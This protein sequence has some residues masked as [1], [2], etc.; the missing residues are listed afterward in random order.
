LTAQ[1]VHDDDIAGRKRRDEGLLD[2]G[3]KAL[4]VDG[5]IENAWDIDPIGAKGGDKGQRGP[6]A[7]RRPA[8][9]LGSAFAP[10]P[11]RRH[12]GLGPGL[13]DEDQ[14]GRINAALVLA[15]LDPPSR[16]RWPLL[17]DGEQSF[18]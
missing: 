5:T 3:G 14:P 4:P 12:V 13:I 8:D 16:N 17:L 1:I 11:D 7:K 2:P 15:P 10:P 6:F 18:F 9:E